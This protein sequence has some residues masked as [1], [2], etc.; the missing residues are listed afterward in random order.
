MAK[1]KKAKDKKN[2]VNGFMQEIAGLFAFVLMI[3]MLGDIGILGTFLQR[4]TITLFGVYFWL[5]GLILIAFCC[6]M[7]VSRTKPAFLAAKYVGLYLIFI[8]AVIFSH[9]DVWRMFVMREL[10]FTQGV[11]DYFLRTDVLADDAIVGG[12]ILG[13]VIWFML[14]GLFENTGMWILATVTIIYGFLLICGVT[15]QDLW[16]MRKPGLISSPFKKM[17][18]SMSQ[19]VSTVLNKKKP[20]LATASASLKAKDK[21]QESVKTPVKITTK[22]S[23]LEI[24]K[25]KKRKSESLTSDPPQFKIIDYDQSSPEIKVLKKEKIDTT[26]NRILPPLDFLIKHEVKKDQFDVRKEEADVNGN[27]LTQTF[28]SFGVAAEVNEVHIG[29]SVTRYEVTPDSGVKVNKITGLVDDIALAL[30]V[31][32]VRIEAPIPGKSA[33]GIEIPNKEA[34]M[35]SFR[36]LMEELSKDSN[37]NDLTIILGQDISGKATYASL[38]KM[39]HLLVAGATGSGKSVCINTMICSLLMRF[40]ASEVK[41]LLVD[42]K[43][44]ELARYNGLPHLLAP[45]VTDP[46]LASAALKEVV[47]EMERRYE[48]FAD[49]GVRDI[50]SYNKWVVREKDKREKDGVVSTLSK[51]AFNVIILDELADLMMVAKGEVEDSIMRLTQMARAAGIHLVVATQ[52][53]SVDIIT[54]VIKSNIPSRIAFGVSSGTDSRTII[55]TVG[56]EKLL[57]RGDMLFS[58]MGSSSPVR[59]QG[60]FITDDE[61]LRIVEWIK[62]ENASRGVVVEDNFLARVEVTHKNSANLPSDD[63]M[64]RDVLAFAYESKYVTTSRL[65]TRFKIGYNRAARIVSD[66]ENAGIVGQAE[67]SKGR[68]VYLSEETYREMIS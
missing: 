11:G 32:G 29:P 37:L 30:A 10:T 25:N 53:P 2:G 17:L 22:A 63:P 15:I 1:S 7:I 6:H 33:V 45:V 31:K 40:T 4:V 38:N 14:G 34:Q 49:A 42:P 19:Q 51:M 28:K 5:F 62:N 39:P 54:G 61:V 23:P 55:D 58:P 46:Q 27:K 57:G 59:V 26:I 66:L 16:E 13:A 60:A 56:A 50:E 41:L 9:T 64:V 52:R 35:V 3:L 20:V 18:K 68:P 12:G 48:L 47:A 8:G 67:G 44:V 43:K 65:Q 21:S 24:I 36:G